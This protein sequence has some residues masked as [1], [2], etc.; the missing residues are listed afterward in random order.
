MF[1]TFAGTWII[2]KGVLRKKAYLELLEITG[3]SRPIHLSEQILVEHFAQQLEEVH[4]YLI[5]GLTLEQF[6]QLAFPLVVIQRIQKSFDD[7]RHSI[8]VSVCTV[9]ESKTTRGRG[10][11]YSVR[12]KGE[13]AL[14]DK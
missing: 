9:V 12:G 7:W 11:W 5:K 1:P 3:I 10:S 6:E 13:S 4:L 2:S 14:E 8:T